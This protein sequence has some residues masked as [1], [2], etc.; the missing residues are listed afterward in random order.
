MGGCA[1][2]SKSDGTR[3]KELEREAKII[4]RPSPSMP[5]RGFCISSMAEAIVADHRWKSSGER[6][7]SV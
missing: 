4:E 5:S 7:R 6:A 2:K 3:G 1:R